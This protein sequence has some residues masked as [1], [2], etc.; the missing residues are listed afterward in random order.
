MLTNITILDR[1]MSLPSTIDASDSWG[2]LGPHYWG[3]SMGGWSRSPARYQCVFGPQQ[4]TDLYY[5][6]IGKESWPESK[7]LLPQWRRRRGWRWANQGSPLPASPPGSRCACWGG[8]QDDLVALPLMKVIFFLHPNPSSGM[9]KIK[10]FVAFQC[11]RSWS[12]ALRCF[13]FR[14]TICNFTLIAFSGG[15]KCVKGRNEDVGKNDN[16]HRPRWSR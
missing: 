8:G 1:N 3:S 10:A 15:G 4:T 6:I 16:D 7:Q 11:L 14:I 2:L 9:T 13:N 5:H 12:M